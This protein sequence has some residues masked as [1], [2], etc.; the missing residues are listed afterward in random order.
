MLLGT[1]GWIDVH[2]RFHRMSSI[3]IWRGKTPQELTFESS[4]HFEVI[5]ASECIAAGLTESD[6]MPLR[7]TLAVQE[8][9][10]Q[11]LAQLHPNA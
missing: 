7:D 6:I 5:H 3:T 2:P 4:Y 1:E 8:L 10:A 11:V 9:M